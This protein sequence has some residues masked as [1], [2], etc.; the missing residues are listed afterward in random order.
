[1]DMT[2]LPGQIWKR[3]KDG[4]YILILKYD[5]ARFIHVRRADTRHNWRIEDWGL[6]RKYFLPD[7]E[8]LCRPCIT[9][10]DKVEGCTR[11]PDCV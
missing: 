5:G 1:M 4:V 8:L 9:G 6:R 2:I 7:Q 3:K 10:V 11:T